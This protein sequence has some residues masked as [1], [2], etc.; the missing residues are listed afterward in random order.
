MGARGH[1]DSVVG[2]GAG[3]SRGRP[4]PQKRHRP[5]PLHCL[6]HLKERPSPPHPTP[7]HPIP[8]QQAPP[9]PRRRPRLGA[10]RVS[11]RPPFTPLPPAPKSRARTLTR[12]EDHALEGEQHL[13]EA[14]L[15][16]LPL[17]AVAAPVPGAQQAQ[18]H[19]AVGVPAE[20]KDLLETCPPECNQP[21]SR[22]SSQTIQDRGRRGKGAGGGGRDLAQG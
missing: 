21:T 18:A 3:I 20:G 12:D 2:A 11:H 22:A 15:P 16:W 8:P 6:P 9:H 5:S 4:P 14:G 17:L 1:R 13:E 7:S 10:S 19:L